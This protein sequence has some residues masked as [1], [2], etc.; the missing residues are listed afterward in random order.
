[1]TRCGECGSTRVDVNPSALPTQCGSWCP[2]CEAED[3]VIDDCGATVCGDP[4]QGQ[5]GPCV[6]AWDH[7]AFGVA[8]CNPDISTAYGPAI[9][10]PGGEREE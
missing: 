3:T 9:R 5:T 2:A 4:T 8:E 7:K 10:V 6:L 1:M